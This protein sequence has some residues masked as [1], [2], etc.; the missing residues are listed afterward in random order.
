MDDN[1][2]E[3]RLRTHLHRRFDNANPSPE[4]TAS[5]HQIL[6]TEPRSVGLGV[7]RPHARTP[8]WS[9]VGVAAAVAILAVAVIRFGAVTTP[10]D[11]GST[12]S[13]EPTSG[14][15]RSFVVVP[16]F[17]A[18]PTGQETGIATE[19]L[20][21]RLKEL[22]FDRVSVAGPEFVVFEPEPT[23]GTV[24]SVLGATGDI[25]FVPL[26]AA[27]YG[28]GGLTAEIGEPL[29]RNEPALFGWDG[30]ASVTRDTSDQP[31]GGRRPGVLV[32]LTPSAKEMFATYTE[33]HLG[34]TFAIVIDG[35]VALLPTI[36][37]PIAGGEVLL[38]PGDD[39]H[40]DETRAILV[41]GELPES[42]APPGVAVPVA[43]DVIRASVLREL[44]SAEIRSMEMDAIRDG[45]MWIAVWRI[46]V[47][48]DFV[49]AC[50]STGPSDPGGCAQ[51]RG[52][53]VT[54]DASNGVP[55]SREYLFE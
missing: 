26:P 46:V 40:F 38:T 39:A 24:M 34:E 25:E 52:L 7:L 48:G 5:V 42:W 44:P 35:R 19:I 41:G 4:L 43:L 11:P 9:L 16:P 12:P 21:K 37:E 50:Q 30:I 53:V 2:L 45:G 47:D 55:I 28:N 18:T 33:T 6:R 13:P 29:P 54:F 3:A 27:H 10:G 36:N 31:G 51:V 20:T 1:D 17:G 14:I 49:G 22:G 8:S 32:T 23:D 15:E